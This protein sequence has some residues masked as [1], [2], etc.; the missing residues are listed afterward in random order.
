MSKLTEYRDKLNLNQ[1]EVSRDLLK[2]STRSITVIAFETG[3]S[4]QSAFSRAL[5][6]WTN[7]SPVEFRKIQ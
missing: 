3:F 5:K 1:E 4:G 6:N 7:Q 2:N